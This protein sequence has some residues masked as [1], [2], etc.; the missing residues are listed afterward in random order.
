MFLSPSS[1]SSERSSYCKECTREYNKKWEKTKRK[2]PEGY[3][4]TQLPAARLSKDKNRIIIHVKND[5]KGRNVT[6]ELFKRY[7]DSDLEW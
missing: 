6:K 5:E 1:F 4:K 2:R 3:Y 7:P